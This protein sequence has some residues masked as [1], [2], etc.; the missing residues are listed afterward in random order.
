MGCN[1][2]EDMIVAFFVFFS[3]SVSVVF[4]GYILSSVYL[5]IGKCIIL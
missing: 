4:C 2:L 3:T 1:L 5:E